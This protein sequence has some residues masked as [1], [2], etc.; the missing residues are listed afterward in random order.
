[1]Y[2]NNCHYI[3]P[4]L[5]IGI[6]ILVFSTLSTKASFISILHSLNGAKFL[7]ATFVFVLP[8]VTVTFPVTKTCALEWSQRLDSNDC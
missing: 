5:Y 4:N 3:Q 6:A 1:M 2:Q 7:N 8:P